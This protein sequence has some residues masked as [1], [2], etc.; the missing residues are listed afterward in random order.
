MDLVSGRP[1]WTSSPSVSTISE[2]LDRDLS[3]DVLIVGGG[4]IGALVADTLS[5]EGVETVVVDRRAPGEGSTS[6][7]TA[8]LQYDLDVPLFKL[9]EQMPKERAVR[10]FKLGVESIDGLQQLTRGLDVGFE[11]KKSLYIASTERAAEELRQEFEIRKSVGLS[12]EW[13]DRVDLRSEWGLDAAAAIVSEAAAEVDPVRLTGALLRRSMERGVRAFEHVDVVEVAESDPLTIKTRSGPKIR[14]QS[15]IHAGGYEA[16]RLL[17]TGSADIFATF[18]LRS[19][20]IPTGFD[21]WRDRSLL[22]EYATPYLYARWAGNRVMIGG[23]DVPQ[24]LNED[25]KPLL[26]DKT[27]SLV[28]K[29][30]RWFPTLSV[31][32]ET[33]W[34]GVVASTHDGLG[35]IGPVSERSN[36]LMAL[37]YGGNGTTHGVVA[38][39]ILADHILR[40]KNTDAE[41]FRVRRFA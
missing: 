17:P 33:A 20:P 25:C 31:E 15:I 7:N 30:N 24:S 5:S 9:V 21:E 11:R 37:C 32:V 13:V 18:A 1:P 35:F 16:A 39:R 22:W 2:P 14:C 29:F 3:T 34:C 26:E 19:K 8:L 12:A 6:A 38:G 40:R 28:E 41:I 27:A 10:A 36:V 4:V 23:E